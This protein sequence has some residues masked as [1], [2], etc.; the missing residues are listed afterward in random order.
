MIERIATSIVYVGG[1]CS[2]AEID[3]DISEMKD[4]AFQKKRVA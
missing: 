3:V 4:D 1:W 2:I